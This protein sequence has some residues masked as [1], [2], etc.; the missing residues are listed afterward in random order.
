MLDGT[1]VFERPGQWLRCALHAHSTVSD[2]DLSPRAL[3]RQYQTAG[4]DVLA[5]TDHWRLVC[6]V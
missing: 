4:F 1:G 2:G 5:I 6:R 3:A